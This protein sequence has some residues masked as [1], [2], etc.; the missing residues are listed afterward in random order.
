MV[1]T[2]VVVMVAPLYGTTRRRQSRRAS[3]GQIDGSPPLLLLTAPTHLPSPTNAPNH[4]HRLVSGKPLSKPQWVLSILS[5]WLLGALVACIFFHGDCYGSYKN[6]YC[7]LR[8]DHYHYYG[9]VPCFLVTITS[10]FTMAYYYYL[11]YEHVMEHKEV[12]RKKGGGGGA[13]RL[14]SDN[15]VR[16]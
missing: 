5:A 15:A 3:Q 1:V 8:K 4:T 7:V 11:A 13:T 2:L 6:I 9:T 16:S 12:R 10:I 14:R